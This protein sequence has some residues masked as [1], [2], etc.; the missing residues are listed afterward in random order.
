M[1]DSLL[2][3]EVTLKSRQ[4][5]SIGQATKVTKAVAGLICQSNISYPNLQTLRLKCRSKRAQLFDKKADAFMQGALK[6]RWIESPAVHVQITE[7]CWSTGRDMGLGYTAC[8]SE[9]RAAGQVDCASW[10]KNRPLILGDSCQCWKLVLA[11]DSMS[12]IHCIHDC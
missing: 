4:P 11:P 7:T 3:T 9:V 6:R 8:T 1:Y 12:S 2:P 10:V 5:K